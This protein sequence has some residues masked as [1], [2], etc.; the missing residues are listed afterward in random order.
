MIF[1]MAA[2]PALAGVPM[3]SAADAS[4]VT[5]Q[6]LAA[7]EVLL[8]IS[9]LGTATSRAELAT[10]TGSLASHGATEAAARRERDAQI[11]R[12]T[13]A[14][15]RVG[16]AAADLM[17][18]EAETISDMAMTDMGMDMQP[19]DTAEAAMDAAANAAADAA[20]VESTSCNTCPASTDPEFMLSS[21]VEVR[22]RNPDKVGELTQALQEAGVE[23]LAE[24]VYAAGDQS[25]ARRTARAQALASA[26][27][28][29]EAYAATLDL[30]VVRV[31]RVTER[32]GM[33]LMSLML[34]ESSPL[35][36]LFQNQE[37]SQGPDIPTYVAVGVDFAL[38]PQ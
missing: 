10:V 32:M 28:D 15:R 4:P 25:E 31:V 7:N 14:A 37:Q 6:P 11:R 16:V 38:G 12:V 21:G 22:L 19:E 26:R 1:G 27:A 13:A 30:R 20:D 5:T 29:A 8:E 33:D 35:R 24:P 18:G 3:D 34:S 17:I 23:V 2:L 36:R 9:A